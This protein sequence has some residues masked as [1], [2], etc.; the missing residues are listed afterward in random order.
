MTGK[1]DERF[2]VPLYSVAEAARHL[3]RMPASTLST[4]VDGYVRGQHG[5]YRGE[6][7]VTAFTPKRRGYPRLPFVGL[8]EAYALNAFRKA[9]VPLQRIRASLDA[10]VAERGPHAL[11]SEHLITDGAEVLWHV[12]AE[13]EREA[14]EQLVVPRLGQR[15]F[16][17][18][19]EQYLR[20]VQFDD[21]YA[22]LIWLPRYRDA[23]LDVVI[24]PQRAGGQPIFARTGVAVDNVLGRIRGGEDPEETARDF[25]IPSEDLR[26]ALELSA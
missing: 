22:S 2:T 5:Q 10:L 3:D 23:H 11:A 4:W 20:E 9:G 25:G 6:P 15:V 8:A 19:V 18:V 26:T 21:G 16:T 7:L 1:D 24:D 13:G 12:Q 17:R 14:L